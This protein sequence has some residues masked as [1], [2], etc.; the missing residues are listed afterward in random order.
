[1]AAQANE[2]A[3]EDVLPLVAK[4][5]TDLALNVETAFAT[6]GKPQMYIGKKLWRYEIQ[7]EGKY[8]Q[9]RKGSGKKRESKY[10]GTFETLPDVKRKEAYSANKKS[11]S[12]PKASRATNRA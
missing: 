12:R 4:D 6:S 3:G 5:Q 10:G 9:W 11:K 1:V 8:W 7:G 2:D